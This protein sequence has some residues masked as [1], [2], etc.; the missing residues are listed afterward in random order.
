MPKYLPAES[1]LSGKGKYVSHDVLRAIM[2]FCSV[3]LSSNC[4]AFWYVTLSK[5]S[6]LFSCEM[7][8][9]KTF[10]V[11]GKILHDIYKNLITTTIIMTSV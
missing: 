2:V 8:I 5:S 6:N 3:D 10:R 11:W 9:M 7:E 4:A 1:V